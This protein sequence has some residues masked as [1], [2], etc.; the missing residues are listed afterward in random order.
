MIYDATDL[1]PRDVLF[2]N[3]ERAGAALSPDGTRIGFLAP[4]DGV[5]NVWVGPLDDLSAAT[6]VTA[7]RGH[8]VR[9]FV[10]AH[11]DRT[12]LYLRD[13]DGD[14]NWRLYTLDLQTGESTLR[15][16]GEGVTAAV[17][18]HNRWHPT[19]VLVGL[20]AD[21]PQLHDVYSLDLV[22]GELTKVESN[23]GFAG[24]LVDSEQQVRGGA[25]MTPD[26]G[27]AVLLRD[28]SGEFVPWRQIGP[29]D[30]AS[31]N[32]LGYTRDGS[33]ML[34]SSSEGVNAGRLVRL[35]LAT[36]V[37]TVLAED[38]TYDVSGMVTDPETLEPLSVVF[39]KER[40]EW[41]HL[42]A[43]FG[44]EI[45]ALRARLTG[46][47]GIS[48]DRANRTWLVTESPSDG[49]VRYYRYDRDS[50]ELSLLFVHKPALERYD[51]APMEPFAFTSRDGLTVHGYVTYP[52]GVERAGLPAVLN[53][54]GG[55]WY[56]DSWG[57]NAEAQWLAN[58]GYACVQVNFRGSTGYGKA[59]LNAGDREWGAAM[60]DD[61]L[62]AVDHLANTG[63]I[64]RERVGIYGGSYGGYAALIGAAFTPDVFRCAV[65]MVGPSNLSTLIESVPEY[66]QPQIALFHTKVGNPETEAE[67]LWS[68]SPLSRVDDIVIPVLIA[69]GKNDPRVKEAEAQ[70]IVDAMADKGLPYEYLLFDDEGHGLV[71]PEN[72]ERF[73]AAAESF[74]A[75]HLGGRAE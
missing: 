54:H 69:Q 65:D 70:Q 68:R 52:V 59:F 73:Y 17:L 12:L 74:L 6:P 61:L 62:D 30:V 5:M 55:P 16:P 18:S 36:G 71:R 60:H 3:P 72:R 42:D 63:T 53:V 57:Y 58:R 4:V 43:D 25:A 75:T 20:N 51:L 32:V 56:R 22:S 7:D 37:E 15:T 31:T 64:D 2:G 21:N 49:P 66:W 48:R 19:T 67:F 23:P 46:D 10:F 27:V 28:E 29:E 44:A 11:D 50:R 9:V 45:D 35:D 41:V 34:L 1:I 33:A 40:D 14:E 47:F 39:D 26:G 13:S 8:G 38:P 24:W